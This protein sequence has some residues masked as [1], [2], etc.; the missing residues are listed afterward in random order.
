MTESSPAKKD[1]KPKKTV[2]RVA[3]D[4]PKYGDMILEALKANAGRKGT[5]KQQIV[6]YVKA[7]YTVTSTA[8][9]TRLRLALKRLVTTEMVTQVK[10]NGFNGSFKLLKKKVEKKPVNK[11]A[12]AAVTKRPAAKKTTAPAKKKTISKKA[13][14]KKSVKK[15]T[16][17]TKKS[18]T[19]SASAKK[20]KKTVAKKAPAKKVIKKTP[21]KKAPVKKSKK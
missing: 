11:S 17:A 4:H 13:T 6:K 19:K 20:A 2:K 14:P 5:S 18:A 9:D 16:A 15:V 8:A 21:K 3:A 10:G 1:G 7:N 12:K